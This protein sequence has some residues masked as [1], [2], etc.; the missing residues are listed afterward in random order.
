MNEIRLIDRYLTG[1]ATP[2]EVSAVEQQLRHDRVF[3]ENVS[4]QRQ[5][6]RIVELHR[7]HRV[8]ELAA[9]LHERLF[10]AGTRNPFRDRVLKLFQS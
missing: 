8:R 4:L 2:D 3:G 1:V 6:Y 7:R 5:V 10:E 9:S